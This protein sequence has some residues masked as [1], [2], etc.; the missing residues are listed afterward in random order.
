MNESAEYKEVKTDTYNLEDGAEAVLPSPDI[1]TASAQLAELNTEELLHKVVEAAEH[2]Q[3][4]EKL[5]ELRHEV[6][7]K[8]DHPVYN[9]NTPNQVGELLSMHP[10]YGLSAAHKASNQSRLKRLVHDKSMYGY[11]IR[12]GFVAALLCLIL[13]IIVVSLFTR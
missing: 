6:K 11:A 9:D 5:L 8:P 3:A 7:D 10:A 4:L 1:L 12:Y 13:A 2:N